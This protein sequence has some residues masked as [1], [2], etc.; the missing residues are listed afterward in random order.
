MTKITTKPA[1]GDK[2]DWNKYL[3][4]LKKETVGCITDNLVP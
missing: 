4:E 3:N 1:K 2:K